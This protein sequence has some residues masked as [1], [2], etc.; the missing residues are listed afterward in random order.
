MKR[1][2]WGVVAAISIIAVA[3]GVAV[4]GLAAA[5][6]YRLNRG[7]SFVERIPALLGG[8]TEAT[9]EA[10]VKTE[11][12]PKW[13]RKNFKKEKEEVELKRRFDHQPQLSPFFERRKD[14]DWLEPFGDFPFERFSFDRADWIDELVEDGVMSEEEADKFKSWFGALPDSLDKGIPDFSGD[15]DFEFDTEDGRFRFR[16]SWDDSRE[17]DFRDRDDRDWEW[18]KD[19]GDKNGVWFFNPT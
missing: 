15:K 18:K 9:D 16:W 6:D 4:I 7:D 11:E 13:E 19:R 17:H 1:R 3:F 14:E 2:F 5:Q 8:E 10:V 12:E